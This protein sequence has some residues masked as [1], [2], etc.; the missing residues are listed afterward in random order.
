MPLR[1]PSASSSAWPK[2]MPTSSTVWCA[3]VSRSPPASTSSPSLPWRASRSSMW[4]RNPTP[5]L[6][7]ASP[8][9]RSIDSMTSV[10]PVLRSLL[11]DLLIGTLLGPNHRR[12]AVHGE[13]LRLG[14][15]LDVR[16]QLRRGALGDLHGGD[17]AAEDARAERPGESTGATGRQHVV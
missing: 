12:L 17:L 15:R 7:L 2:T 11:A 6:A 1:S 9:S 10:S 16:C 5:V 3:P 4:S 14:E 8:P 13:S